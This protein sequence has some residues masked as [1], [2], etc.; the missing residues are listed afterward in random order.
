MLHPRERIASQVRDGQQQGSHLQSA[1]R[2][3]HN[4]VATAAVGWDAFLR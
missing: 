3:Q 1:V 2:G 4:V